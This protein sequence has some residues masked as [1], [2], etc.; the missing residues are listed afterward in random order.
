MKASY[1]AL[2]L[3]I[4][5]LPLPCYWWRLSYL[6]YVSL[7]FQEF[8]H[9]WT[10]LCT[11]GIVLAVIFFFCRFIWIF[12]SMEW[13]VL[14]QIRLTCKC[15]FTLRVSVH[16]QSHTF[17]AMTTS[18]IW[19]FGLLFHWLIVSSTN[20]SI[21]NKCQ[22]LK[23][24]MKNFQMCHIV[25]AVGKFTHLHSDKCHYGM[26]TWNIC[27]IY[28]SYLQCFLLIQTHWNLYTP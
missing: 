15:S 14:E 21:W 16:I 27:G 7:F 23:F 4:L 19:F 20:F 17:S 8:L 12:Y 3:Y 22:I 2:F 10:L 5:V 26:W 25:I 13:H 9:S 28:I 18:A 1:V 11:I 6:C 24:S